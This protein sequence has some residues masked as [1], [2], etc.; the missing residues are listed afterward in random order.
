MSLEV[1]LQKR[2]CPLEIEVDFENWGRVENKKNG[3]F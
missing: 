1:D 2:E 3:L